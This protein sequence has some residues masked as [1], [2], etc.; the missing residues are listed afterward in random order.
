MPSNKMFAETSQYACMAAYLLVIRKTPQTLFLLVRTNYVLDPHH[1]DSSLIVGR[2]WTFT[3]C[4]YG[5]M[6]KWSLRVFSCIAGCR[7]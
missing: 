5:W 2:F 6:E 4:E 7:L 3:H 1:H